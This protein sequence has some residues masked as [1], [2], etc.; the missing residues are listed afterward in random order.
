MLT[1]AV[2][3]LVAPMILVCVLAG[4]TH[5]PQERTLSV[6]EIIK[7]DGDPAQRGRLVRTIAIVTYCDADWRVLFVEDHGSALYVRLPEGA[8]AQSGDQVQITGAIAPM[9]TGLDRATIL[10]LSKNNPLPPPLRVNDY[11]TLPDSLSSFVSVEGTVRWTGVREGRPAIQLSSGGKPLLAYLRRALIDDLP[12]LGSKVSVAGVD[13]ANVDSNGRVRGSKLFI[14]SAQY[15]K[16]LH[17]GPSDPFSLPVKTLA[18]LNK[19]PA[20]TLV[21]ISGKIL[22]GKQGLAITDGKLTVPLS[23]RGFF[24]GS[25]ADVV[26]FWTGQGLED[27]L[28]RPSS[29]SLNRAPAGSPALSG[30]IV[31]LS[32]LKRLSEAEASAHRRVTV[33]AVVTYFDPDW[34]L[35]FVQDDTAAAFV[36]LGDLEM[37]FRPGD[38]IDI[39]GVSSL[40]DFAPVIVNPKVGLVG[41]A[42]LPVPFKADLLDGNLPAADS[43][44]CIFHGVVHTAEEHG[45]HTILKVGAG[46]TEVTVQLPMLI[47]GENLV[48]QEISVTGVFGVLFNDRRQAVG[49]QILV[50]SPEFLTVMDR[51]GKRNGPVTIASLRKY[52]LD[53]DERHSVTLKGTVVLK[54]TP[55]TIFIQDGSAGIQVRATEAVNVADGDR[56]TVRGFITPGDY[57]PALEDAV[58]TRDAGGDLPKPTEISAKSALEGANDSGYV[59]V[60]G[61]LTAIHTDPS[62]TI[63]V[64]NDKGTFFNAAGPPNGDLASLRT[65]SEVEVRGVCQVLVDRFPFDI[66][67]FT[68][69]FDSPRSVTLVKAGAWWDPRKIAW[70]L[71]LIVLLAA[72]SSLWAALLQRQV[73]VQTRELQDSLQ[74]KRKARQF[75]MA[76]NEVLES[77]ARNAPLAESMSRLAEAMQEQIADSICAIVMPPDGRSFLNGKPTPV[78]IAP[79]VPEPIQPGVAASAGLGAGAHGGWCRTEVWR[80]E[81]CRVKIAGDQISGGTKI[82]RAKI[83][84]AKIRGPE[85]P[86]AISSP[87]LLQVLRRSGVSLHDGQATQ[88]LSG[89][90]A[91]VG[92]LIVFSRTPC[93]WKP[94]APGKPFCS[95]LH[96]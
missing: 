72:V 78:L 28:A 61:T 8:V 1:R 68:L 94:K 55:D 41:R 4:C 49:H 9:S 74:A 47:H 25:S 42:R 80:V 90:G 67:G 58:V 75:D 32:Q 64:L 16:V 3:R 12:T 53:A 29:Y 7:A 11:V 52:T 81:I 60:R 45:P 36:T 24:Q 13:S 83:C 43:K 92:L 35:L 77:I 5:S 50:P 63:L 88:V 85:R 56:V 22:E 84:G 37:Q 39:S 10:V 62:S 70:A 95:P 89:S 51:E 34:R 15:I 6:S 57:S 66:R 2:R 20:G 14:P 23:L 46:Q 21:H 54:S 93:P 33:R 82:C 26:G 69:A 79:G 40:G 48:D 18:E 86:T 17:P 65:G 71:M 91:A 27:A 73:D 44:W 76:R 96:A 30:D 31:H 59:S 87:S 19:A 38:L